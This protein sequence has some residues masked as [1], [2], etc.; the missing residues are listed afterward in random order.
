M[1]KDGRLAAAANK[2][3]GYFS[4]CAESARRELKDFYGYIKQT[5]LFIVVSCAIFLVVYS[6]WIAGTYPRMDNNSLINYPNT[7]YNWLNIGRQGGILTKKLFGLLYF[8]PMLAT[9]VGYLVVCMAG[10]LF[11][12]LFWRCN[13]RSGWACALTWLPMFLSPIL[14]EQFYFD[15]QTFEIAFAFALSA[16]GIGLALYGA[17]RKSV[18]ALILAFFAQS[19]AIGTYQSFAVLLFAM[20]L[21]C[22]TLLYRKRTA[23]EAAG[24]GLGAKTYVRALVLAAAVFFAA[25]IVYTVTTLLWFLASS[26]GENQFKWTQQPI[27]TSLKSIYAQVK[28]GLLGEGVFYTWLYLLFAILCTGTAVLDA[29]HSK[30]MLGIL[31][32]AL[33]VALQFSPFVMNVIFGG[34]VSVRVQFTYSFV[35]AADMLYLIGREWKIIPKFSVQFGFVFVILS[36]AA[37]FSQ[38]NITARLIYTDVMRSQEDIRLATI[39][40]RDIR[41]VSPTMKPL[42]FIGHRKANLNQSC[43]RGEVIGQSMFEYCYYIQPRYCHS[44]WWACDVM[45]TVGFPFTTAGDENITNA[46]IYARDNDM[47]NYPAEGSIQDMGDYIIVKLSDDEF[48]NELPPENADAPASE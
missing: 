10:I 39:I 14:T 37:F 46:R 44:T 29:V 26:Y 30:H 18:T 43:I 31:N 33:A 4:D 5:Y 2:A 15:I 19:W 6:S 16:V 34:S 20:L 13:G 25:A 32:V 17:F 28:N 22:F 42:A 3:A 1:N 12:Y 23:G 21:F 8:N 45:A 35:F 38:L 7:T 47:P 9:T 41:E 24:E 27:L 40:E 48:V 36:F 11:G